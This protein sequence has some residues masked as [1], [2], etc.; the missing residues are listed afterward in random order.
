MALYPL[1]RHGR[2]P[3]DAIRHAAGVIEAHTPETPARADFLAY[4]N[5]F[6]RLAFPRLDV[7]NLIGSEKM[8]E[9]PFLREVMNEGR[10]EVK[11][12]DILKVLQ[13]RFGAEVTRALTPRLDDCT[14]L[15]Q[16]NQ[17]FD[18]ALDCASVEEF[19]SALA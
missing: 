17:F 14:N 7:K 8:K 13:R 2:R 11:R 12:A 3:R 5:T 10:I 4:L 16:L 18:L 9:S 1:C 6:G 19:R 15:D